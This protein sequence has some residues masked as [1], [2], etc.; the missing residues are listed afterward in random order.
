VEAQGTKVILRG[1]VRSWAEYED[2]E[3]AAWSA[4]GVVNVDNRLTVEEVAEI[5]PIPLP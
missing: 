2:A 3:W 1:R 5:S 4:P